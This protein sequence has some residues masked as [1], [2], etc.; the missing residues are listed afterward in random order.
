[1]PWL[2]LRIH[3]QTV[4]VTTN[5]SAI[6]KRKIERKIDSPRMCWS[7]R[8]ASSSPAAMQ[9]PTKTTVKTMFTNTS[10]VQKRGVAKTARVV[11]PAR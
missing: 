4:P 2:G 6:G 1:M 7:T 8:I 10:L 11:A 9:P 5:E 3:A